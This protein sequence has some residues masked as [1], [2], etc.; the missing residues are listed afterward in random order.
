MNIPAIHETRSRHGKTEWNPATQ[1]EIESD[2]VQR[3]WIES[4]SFA[5]ELCGVS[6][7][8]SRH[9][10]IIRQHPPT[11]TPALLRPPARPPLRGLKRCP[12]ATSPPPFIPRV[13]MGLSASTRKPGVISSFCLVPERSRTNPVTNLGRRFHLAWFQSGSQFC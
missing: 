2:L 5:P 3:E 6:T 13:P 11:T 4:G 8:R 1:E 9:P 10:R 12:S 7:S